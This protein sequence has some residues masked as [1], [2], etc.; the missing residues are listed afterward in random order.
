[1][2]TEG[3]RAETRQQETELVLHPDAIPEVSSPPARTGRA[4]S[5]AEATLLDERKA[6]RLGSRH[7]STSIRDCFRAALPA[8]IA[9]AALASA[10]CVTRDRYDEV[11]VDLQRA[12]AQSADHAT[13]AAS[14]QNQV[15]KLGAD[16]QA[17]DAKLG[18]LGTAQADLQRKV[19][20]LVL[21]NAELSQ[22]LK[23]AGQSVEQLA[24][25]R[26]NLSHALDDMRAKL[27]ELKRQQAAAEARAAEFRELLKSFQKMVDAGK[28]K[29]GIRR[30]R[31]VLELP[32]DI[33]F[34][35]GKTELKA[36]GKSALADVAKVLRGLPGRTFQVA[37]HTD[38]VKIQS[39][40][41]PSNWELSTAR[42]VEVTKL[43]VD[44]GM[45]PKM[46]SAA[47]YGEWDPA[48]DNATPDGRAK[49]RRI[50]I[51]LVPNMEELVKLPDGFADPPPAKGKPAAA[52]P[53]PA[54][55]PVAGK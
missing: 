2:T 47:G 48:A 1:M 30:G 44:N 25:E 35:S 21:L 17:R 15:A 23:S 52:A 29:V 36:A 3:S 20:D 31:M 51:T 10:G 24:S 28:L 27:D 42:A 9:C 6:Q 16:V 26:G 7:L 14:L 12:R 46:L 4:T 39:A 37:G 22:R 40:R 50:E 49:N 33:L 19:D 32:N 55:P 38:N 43:L 34:D 11:L 13:R 5:A 8:M 53:K 54:T 45:D 41:Y 18:E